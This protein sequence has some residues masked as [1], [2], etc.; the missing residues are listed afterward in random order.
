MGFMTLMKS[1]LRHAYIGIFSW[2]RKK[3]SL[4][5]SKD[6]NNC[7]KKSLLFL[8]DEPVYFIKVM[9]KEHWCWVVCKSRRNSPVATPLKKMSFYFMTINSYIFLEMEGLVSLHKEAHALF[10][11]DTT[12][13][14]R[15]H[16]N[17][18]PATSGE[19][20]SMTQPSGP[21]WTA[22][23]ASLC[24]LLNG[25]FILTSSHSTEWVLTMPEVAM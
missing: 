1:I 13:P 17:N 23:P 20:L 5:L 19:Q 11:L 10:G 7:L 15:L 18:S 8:L 24:T 16:W 6:I 3:K 14:L 9:Y 25:I 2:R 12:Q 21:H 22:P 4:H